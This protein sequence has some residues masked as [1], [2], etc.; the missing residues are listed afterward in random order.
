MC[1]LI[2]FKI[3]LHFILPFHKNQFD[4]PT[5]FRISHLILANHLLSFPIILLNPTMLIQG[6][7]F[8]QEQVNQ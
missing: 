5:F 3:L 6:I 1:S 2:F 7:Q 4:H 8:S